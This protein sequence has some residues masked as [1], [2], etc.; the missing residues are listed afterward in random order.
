[1]SKRARKNTA[2]EASTKLAMVIHGIIKHELMTENAR[3]KNNNGFSR[4]AKVNSYKRNKVD[5]ILLSEKHNLREAGQRIVLLCTWEMA[6]ML[7]SG[8]IML[9]QTQSSTFVKEV[10]K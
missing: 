9:V 5:M 8:L 10:C 3:H 7:A 1:M 4:Q 2:A 6:A